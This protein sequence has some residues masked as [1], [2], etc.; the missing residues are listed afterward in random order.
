[1]ADGS[2]LSYKAAVK[3]SKE[4]VKAVRSMRVISEVI[5][6]SYDAFNDRIFR[7]TSS[8]SLLIRNIRMILDDSNPI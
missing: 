5:T 7:R 2:L 6:K 4:W 8:M 3:I 1:M